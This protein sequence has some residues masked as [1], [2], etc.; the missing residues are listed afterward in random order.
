M[1]DAVKLRDPSTL[2]GVSAD[3]RERP[4]VPRRADALGP[5]YLG[6]GLLDRQRVLG[7]RARVRRRGG[8]DGTSESSHTPPTT[9]TAPLP[10]KP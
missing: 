3:H 4:P 7:I 10:F 1:L 8:N 5:E 9:G 2:W 6:E